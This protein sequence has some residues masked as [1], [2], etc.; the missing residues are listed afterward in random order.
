[1]VIR[2]AEIRA[3]TPRER[4]FNRFMTWDREFNASRQGSIIGIYIVR[5]L[6]MKT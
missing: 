4:N 6:K 3:S 2:N 5:D 1:M